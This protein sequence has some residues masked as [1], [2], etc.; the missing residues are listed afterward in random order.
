MQPMQKVKLERTHLWK[1]EFP[2]K[3]QL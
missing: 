1:R 3:K 2:G